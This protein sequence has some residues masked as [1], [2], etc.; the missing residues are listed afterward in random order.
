MLC[1]ISSKKYLR[2]RVGGAGVA[3]CRGKLPSWGVPAAEQL[4][5]ALAALP[6]NSK[7]CSRA[8][9][10]GRANCLTEGQHHP[11]DHH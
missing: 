2:E 6:S 5:H 4:A 8:A 11:R 3:V 7:R 1:F 10:T 9:S